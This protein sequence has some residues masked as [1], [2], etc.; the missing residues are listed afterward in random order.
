MPSASEKASATAMV[1]I[2]PITASF[3]CVPECS[4]TMRPRVVMIP[5]VTPKLRPVLMDSLIIAS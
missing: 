4:P 2:P 5:E 1:R 3:E